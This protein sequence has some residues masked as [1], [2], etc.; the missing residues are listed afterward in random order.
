VEQSDVLRLVVETLDRLQI[1]YAIV[2][3]FASGAWGESRFIQ[4]QALAQNQ[5]PP[6]KE[7]LS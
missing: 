6:R 2:G 3:S 4:I 7:P 1:T 5:A